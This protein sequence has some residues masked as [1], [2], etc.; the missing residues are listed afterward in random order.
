LSFELPQLTGA[1][2]DLGNVVLVDDN[3][4]NTL[5]GQERNLLPLLESIPRRPLVVALALIEESIQ[6]AR[7]A[8]RSVANILRKKVYATGKGSAVEPSFALYDAK[9]L[10]KG[11]RLIGNLENTKLKASP[12]VGRAAANEDYRGPEVPKAAAPAEVRAADPVRTVDPVIEE[13]PVSRDLPRENEN[14]VN[15][16]QP[17]AQEQATPQP[18]KR[19]GFFGACYGMARYIFGMEKGGWAPDVI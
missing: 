11:H 1:N 9:K 12:I 19:R 5:P 2:A 16:T 15:N 18:A 6:E 4:G 7:A 8:G 14:S 3:P 17:P 10:G 13:A